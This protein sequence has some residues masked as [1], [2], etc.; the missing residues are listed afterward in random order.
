[1]RGDLVVERR[2]HLAVELDVIEASERVSALL[3]LPDLTEVVG[4]DAAHERSPLRDGKVARVWPSVDPAV[5]A[6]EVIDAV[7]Q[8]P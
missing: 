8:L 7:A 1:M 6:R 4:G 5:H 2:G 3:R